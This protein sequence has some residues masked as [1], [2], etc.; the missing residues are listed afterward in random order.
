MSPVYND[1]YST[2]CAIPI[3]IVLMSEGKS[4]PTNISIIPCITGWHAVTIKKL[5]SGTQ[6][7]NPKKNG[8]MDTEKNTTVIVLPV[9][10]G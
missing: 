4:S 8:W 1:I 2:P 3:E 5:T 9:P 10:C 6:E 7:Y